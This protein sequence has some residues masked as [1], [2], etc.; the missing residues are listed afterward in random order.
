MA[1]WRRDGCFK[2]GRT[3]HLGKL[4]NGSISVVVASFWDPRTCRHPLRRERVNSPLSVRKNITV[5][6]ARVPATPRRV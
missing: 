5:G 6:T 3:L 1:R 2:H 4:E